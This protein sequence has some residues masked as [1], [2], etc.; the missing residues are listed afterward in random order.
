MLMMDGL[1][2]TQDSVNEEQVGHVGIDDDVK[3]ALVAKR[4]FVLEHIRAATHPCRQCLDL[5]GV[6]LQEGPDV[7]AKLAVDDPPLP[8]PATALTAGCERRSL[9]S[10][11]DHEPLICSLFEAILRQP[12]RVD[13]P[14]LCSEHTQHEQIARQSS[15]GRRHHWEPKQTSPSKNG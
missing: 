11:P 9:P 1:A 2:M 5:S 13:R 4:V 7:V 8:A 10:V 14:A 3:L 12:H 15:S 6:V